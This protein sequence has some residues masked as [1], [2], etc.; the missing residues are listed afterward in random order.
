MV[1]DVFFVDLGLDFIGEID[2]QLLFQGTQ[3]KMGKVARVA[4]LNYSS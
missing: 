2:G 3:Q 1:F 4:H